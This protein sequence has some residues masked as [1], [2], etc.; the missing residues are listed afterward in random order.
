MEVTHKQA[1]LMLALMWAELIDRDQK[2]SEETIMLLGLHFAP[3]FSAKREEDNLVRYSLQVIHE[4]GKPTTEVYALSTPPDESNRHLR[5]DL[6]SSSVRGFIGV[7]RQLLLDELKK[8]F[9]VLEVKT[10]FAYE[11]KKLID[12]QQETPDEDHPQRPS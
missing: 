11:A 12:D 2:V 4:P 3:Y 5:L 8:E 1:S 10:S 7:A 9:P 6:N